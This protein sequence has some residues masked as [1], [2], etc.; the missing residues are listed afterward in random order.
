[1]VFVAVKAKGIRRHVPE[2]DQLYMNYSVEKEKVQLL[3]VPYYLWNNRGI[4]EMQ[5]WIKA[6]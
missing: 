3:A 4:G 1:M 2:T 6:E 5:V